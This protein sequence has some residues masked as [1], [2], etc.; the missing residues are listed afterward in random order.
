[1]IGYANPLIWGLFFGPCL[2]GLGQ[3]VQYGGDTYQAGPP[4]GSVNV[5][6]GDRMTRSVE[7]FEM[8]MYPVTNGEFCLF[9]AGRP[10]YE[11]LYITNP[12][13]TSP[14]LVLSDTGNWTPRDGTEEWPVVNVTWHGANAYCRWMSETSSW[15]YRLP[16]EWE[17][18]YA[19]SNGGLTNY[20]WGVS[21]RRALQ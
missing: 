3:V 1:L 4:P 7:S 9:L 16:T 11:A 10:N 6:D 2:L 8:S 21:R 19:A 15:E 17:W 5:Y 18:E 14:E 20:P 12:D 13:E